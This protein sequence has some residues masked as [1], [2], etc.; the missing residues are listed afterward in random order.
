MPK[1]KKTRDQKILADKRRTTASESLYT[2]T[3]A[4]VKSQPKL[5]AAT[6][7]QPIATISTTS[8]QYL[9]SDLRKTFFFTIFIIIAEFLIYYFTKGV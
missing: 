4:I 1:K 3:P 8:Y 6:I 9:G 2:F 5:P 7:R